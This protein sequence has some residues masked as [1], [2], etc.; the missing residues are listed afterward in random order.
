MRLV[1]L[2][3]WCLSP[4]AFAQEGSVQAWVENRTQLVMEPFP[5]HVEITGS[6]AG[7]LILPEVEDLNLNQVENS[8]SVSIVGGRV[9]Q[10]L[11][12]KFLATPLKSG[13]MTI[14]PFSV[15]FGDVVKKSEP[16]A[17][18]VLSGGT[19][20]AGAAAVDAWVNQTTVKAGLPFRIYVQGIGNRVDIPAPPDAEGLTWDLTQTERIDT[21]DRR[22]G[23]VLDKKIHGYLATAK[24]EGRLTIPSFDVVVDGATYATQSFDITVVKHEPVVEAGRSQRAPHLEDLLFTHIEVDKTEVYQGE[25]VLLTMELWRIDDRR[26]TT[27][28][29]RGARIEGPSTEGFYAVMLEPSQRTDE[30]NSFPYNVIADRKLLYPTRSGELVIGS[31]HW[32]GIARYPS[33]RRSSFFAHE[34]HEYFFDTTPITVS[35]KSLP[36]PQPAEFSGAVGEFIISARLSENSLLQGVPVKLL[37]EIVGEGNPDAISDPKLP[38]ADMDWAHLSSPER[39]TETVV[40]HQP[41]NVGVTKRFLYTL[42]PLKAGPVT[43]PAITLTYFN[44][45]TGIYETESTTAIGLE[46][47]PSAEA[48]QRL[49][50]APDATAG[51]DGVS[52]LAEDIRPPLPRPAELGPY[53]PNVVLAPVIGVAPVALFA[54][55]ALYAARKRR[56]ASNRGFARAYHAQSKALKRLHDTPR[57]ADPTDELFKALSSFIADLFNVDGTGM[58][59]EDARGILSANSVEQAIVEASVKV[60]RACER[61]RYASQQLSSDEIIALTRASEG[62]VEHLDSVWRGKRA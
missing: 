13:P 23:R 12:L 30:R 7:N 46:V 57:T 20:A 11:K 26:I 24:E 39:D 14:P 33:T 53:R 44:P 51:A 29:P 25:P 49:I 36:A 9:N 52:I 62:I 35:V 21:E 37:V 54:L 41:P 32:E 1:V 27:G 5:L 59:S 43:I 47:T 2:V 16:I 50:V 31:W 18:T 48:D 55:M 8:T 34:E 17:L 38:A 19:A 61:A 10:S 4:S 42:T 45:K 60:L 3:A 28:A 56:F 22:R 40:V 6:G 58:T 15:N